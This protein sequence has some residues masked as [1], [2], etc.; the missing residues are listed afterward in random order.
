MSDLELIFSMLGERSTTEIAR[1]K[2][3]KG[4]VQ[5]KDA[6]KRGGNMAGDARRALEI[7][8]GNKV[9]NKENYLDAPEK[10]KRKRLGK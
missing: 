10:E 7:E 1:T 6:A 5:N 8:T 2:N 9:V 4:F 3:A